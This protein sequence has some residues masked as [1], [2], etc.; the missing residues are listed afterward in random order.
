MTENE[1]VRR[2]MAMRAQF[3][4]VARNEEDAVPD[5]M[6][7]AW[8]NSA[9]SGTRSNLRPA[10]V[11]LGGA[12]YTYLH[13]LQGDIVG[14]LDSVGNLVVEYKHDAWGKPVS[15]RTLTTA[16]DTLASLNPFRYRGYIWDEETGWYYLRSRYYN[17]EWGRFINADVLLGKT[18][19]LLSHDKFTYCRNTPVITLDNSGMDTKYIFEGSKYRITSIEIEYEKS[20]GTYLAPAPSISDEAQNMFDE[21]GIDIPESPWIFIGSEKQG[22]AFIAKFSYC[23]LGN[24]LVAFQGHAWDTIHTIEYRFEYK[25]V[26][27]RKVEE[28]LDDVIVFLRNYGNVYDN[29]VS[30]MANWFGYGGI[31]LDFAS[32]AA[33]TSFRIFPYYINRTK[34]NMKWI[35]TSIN[36]GEYYTRSDK[37]RTYFLRIY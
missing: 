31:L 9:V 3:C 20:G 5:A 12:K 4:H 30:Q 37:K 26:S 16:Y 33:E 24:E 27:K 2:V 19:G 8:K 11:D 15:V 25:D 14:M 10:L 36:T 13:N 34:P 29:P 17:P 22:D 23:L 28:Y 35:C 7:R 18:G 1:F 6:L 21:T 32:V